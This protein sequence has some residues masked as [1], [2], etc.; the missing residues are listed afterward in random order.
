MFTF[1][2]LLGEVTY[3]HFSTLMHV[4]PGTAAE[5]GAGHEQCGG[6]HGHFEGLNFIFRP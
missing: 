4:A 2:S 5:R 3:A 6:D 1:G